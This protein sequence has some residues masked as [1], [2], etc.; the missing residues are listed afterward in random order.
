LK[1]KDGNV[2][3]VLSSTQMINWENGGGEQ[4]QE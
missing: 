3:K 1:Y 4:E 2:I